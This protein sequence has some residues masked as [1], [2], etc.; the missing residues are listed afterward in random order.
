MS[1]K[2]LVTGGAGYIGSHTVVA[3]QQQGYEV[4]ILDNLVNSNEAIIGQIAKITGIRPVFE[5]IDMRDGAKMDKFFEKHSDIAGVIHFAA[6]KAVGEST[7][8]PLRYY[9]NNLFSL[10]NLMKSMEQ[11][12]CNN[13]VFSS[14][15][16]VYGQ[17]DQ[18]PVTENAPVK[19]P[20]SPYGNTKQISEEIIE[21]HVSSSALNAI[22]LRYFNPI[23]AHE[24]ALI[25]ELPI[26]IPNNLVPFI[27]QAA[28][29]KRDTLK[30]FGNDYDTP[31][32]TCIRDYIHV[33]D[34][35]KAHVFAIQ[36]LEKRQNA[37]PSEV[38]NLGT[39]NGYSVMEIVNTFEKVTGIKLNYQIAPRRP[40]DI[41]KVWADTHKANE[42]L[43]WK[44]ELGLETMLKSAWEWEQNLASGII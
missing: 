30:I 11:A 23:G 17:P 21:D 5:N 4:V 38:F 29:G 20:L 36:R 10:I 41:T 24:S 33:M 39:G 35:A 34:L 14:S 1:K 18:L 2:I 15:C 19:T 8:F 16:T 40:G 32:G 28:I 27:T 7:Q 6:F 37:T 42:I 25:G 12:G 13:L 43:G 22:S 31:D 3:L 26:G 44:T 9:E